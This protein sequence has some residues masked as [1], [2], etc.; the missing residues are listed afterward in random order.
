M[1]IRYKITLW[2]KKKILNYKLKERRIFAVRMR[3][4]IGEFLRKL[5]KVN[6]RARNME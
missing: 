5:M 6:E 4:I 1:L 2:K 3:R